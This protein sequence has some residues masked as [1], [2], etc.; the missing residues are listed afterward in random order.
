MA[1]WSTAEEFFPCQS[2]VII[3][4]LFVT[5]LFPSFLCASPQPVRDSSLK[6]NDNIM[7]RV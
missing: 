3:Y 1:G 2:R 5:A 6:E 7:Y 4:F